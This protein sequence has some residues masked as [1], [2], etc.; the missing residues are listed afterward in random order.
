MTR[1]EANTLNNND[2]LVWNDAAQKAV[3]SPRP[4]V[5]HTYLRALVDSNTGAVTYDWAS[6]GGVGIAFI[7]TRAQY[8]TAKLI[9]EGQDGFIPAGSKVIITDED[10]T[11]T[12]D[13]R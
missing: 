6:G 2:L 7:G 5:N 3:N 10:A 12:G 11:I 4:T 1:A 8:N 9:P 13:E